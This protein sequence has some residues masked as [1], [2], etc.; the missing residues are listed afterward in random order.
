MS[1]PLNPELPIWISKTCLLI[2]KAM[3]KRVY[4]RLRGHNGCYIFELDILRGKASLC[5]LLNSFCKYLHFWELVR[6]SGRV[7]RQQD[8]R[9][10][11]LRIIRELIHKERVVREMILLSL[12]HS[13]ERKRHFLQI[14]CSDS[15]QTSSVL[16]S[17]LRNM[18]RDYRHR[19]RM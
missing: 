7:Q 5:Y 10:I 1:K 18:S 17:N 3:C 8:R 2:K 11:H 4:L 14:K 15:M 9:D 19:R 13:S 16:F 6:N 12:Y